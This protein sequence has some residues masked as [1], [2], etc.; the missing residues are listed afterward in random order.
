M[1]LHKHVRTGTGGT[2]QVPIG[3]KTGQIRQLVHL[4][5]EKGE[6]KKTSLSLSFLRQ[7]LNPCTS[8]QVSDPAKKR[9]NE[10]KENKI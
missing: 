10:R 3:G 6:I 9:A 2:V 5:S 1:N 7:P 8:V 4:F